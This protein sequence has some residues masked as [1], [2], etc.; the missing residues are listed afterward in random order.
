MSAMPDHAPYGDPV[1][2]DPLINTEAEQAVLGAVLWRNEL[3]DAVPEGFSA[4]AFG[5]PVH[6][7]LWE[8]IEQ[9]VAAGSTA[10]A[11]ML[12]T[13]F[14]D[15]DGLREVGGAGYLARLGNA[16]TIHALSVD[17]YCGELLD[18]AMKRQVRDLAHWIDGRLRHDP[19]IAAGDLMREVE[20]GLQEA[21]ARTD[22]RAALPIGSALQTVRD[23][24]HAPETVELIPTGIASLDRV[25]KLARGRY[26]VIG[27][28]TSMGKSALA[29]D[30]AGRIAR[31]GSRAEG[32]GI[33]VL[34]FSLEMS[35]ADC[36]ARLLSSAVW[37]RERPIPYQAIQAPAGL[38]DHEV[39]RLDGV[40]GM[41]D[42]LSLWIDDRP[43]LTP[44]QVAM[45]TRRA[46][47]LMRRDN[48]DLQVVVVD[49]ITKMRP[50]RNAR[51]KVVEVGEVSN[52]L[53]EL[54]KDAGV[55]VVACVQIN[56]QTEARE[57][58]RPTLADLRWSGD[59]EQDADAAILMYR[60]AY[61]LER[62]AE[63]SDVDEATRLRERLDQ[64]RYTTEAI[65]A[66]NRR[67]PITT[68][69]LFCD[70]ASNR[71]GDL[72]YH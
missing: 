58:K 8:A 59:I 39:A 54:A 18:L 66:K 26:V 52:A 38:T 51:D 5:Y 13:R 42:G 57:D 12:R 30:L 41:V 6:A 67:G 46:K 53:A 29:I 3:I 35:S 65:I 68:V 9:A 61:Y 15:D 11:T 24:I 72:E 64:V 63:P 21:T 27:G 10:S 70:I 32:P 14:Q 22:R 4:T 37:S 1:P 16:G 45:A 28:R 36:A 31:R 49:H 40:A 60:E 47:R 55:C 34:V 50:D 2:D 69:K 7:R 62:K 44:G 33:G 25:V 23:A 43:G 48:I 20:S 56:R 71:F 19:A 17:H